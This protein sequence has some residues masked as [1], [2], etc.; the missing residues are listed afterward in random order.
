MDGIILTASH[1]QYVEVG[2]QEVSRMHRARSRTRRLR[3]HACCENTGYAD[4]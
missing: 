3:Q 1:C 2:M 4:R